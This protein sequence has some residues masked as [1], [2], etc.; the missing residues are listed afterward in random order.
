MIVEDRAVE[1]AEPV[2]T[3]LVT[4]S[5]V[6]ALL[7]AFFVMLF[8]MSEINMEK[9]N[10]II[11]V[12]S[13]PEKLEEEVQTQLHVAKS[14]PKFELKSALSLDYLAHVLEEH[15]TGDIFLKSAI[16]HRLD[17]LVVVSLP[18]DTMFASGEIELQKNAKEALFRMGDVIASIGNRIDVR[19]HTDPE[20]LSDKNFDSKWVISLARAA[21]VANE[22][23]R[24]GYARQLPI[25]GLADTRF[26]DLDA[27]IPEKMRY[28]LARRVDIV[29]HPHSGRM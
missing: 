29:I 7:L 17:G 3:W 6:I 10:Q 23:R 12:Q 22:L 5:D 15:L 21:A 1:G 27:Q 9:W 26:N 25:Y 4:F 2:G 28:E 8:S 16:V 20:L 19:G 11:G 14:I 24:T 18:S 13:S